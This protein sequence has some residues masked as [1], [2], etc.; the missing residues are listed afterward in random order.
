[1][2]H[3][4]ACAGLPV[5][6]EF[7]FALKDFLA[8]SGHWGAKIL[9][10]S[11]LAR[12]YA[13][14]AFVMAL[15][16]LVATVLALIAQPD[17]KRIEQYALTF[18]HASQFERH[19]DAGPVAGPQAVY[20]PFHGG[21]VAASLDES[22]LPSLRPGQVTT[23]DRY[24]SN[25]LF[26]LPASA[27]RPAQLRI[28]AQNDRLPAGLGAI[29]VGPQ[30]PLQDF[31]R[32]LSRA[33]DRVNQAMP[34]TVLLCLL[35]A[36]ALVF[37]SG[38]PARYAYMAGLFA[39]SAAIEFD[40][41]LTVAG[42]H[43]RDFE[44][45]V[46]L[47]Y[48]SFILLAISEWW[49]RPDRER[50][51]ILIGMAIVGAMVVAGD[52]WFGM[53]AA[54]TRVLRQLAFIGPLIAA[55]IY[56]ILQAYRG[57]RGASLEALVALACSALA[58]FAALI[59]LVRLYTVLPPD[60]LTLVLF[61]TKILGSLSLLTLSSAA[62]IHEYRLFALRRS[63]TQT[64]D[65]I[66]SGT[67]LAIDEQARELKDEIERRAVSEE[68]VRLT[69]DLHDGLSGQLL[70]LLLKAR[71]GTIA[72][73][74]VEREVERSLAD[75][76]LISSALDESEDG[77]TGTLAKFQARAAQQAD[78]SGMRLDWQQ[79]PAIAQFALARRA[80]LGLLRAMQEA[81]TN[82][83]RHSRGSKITIDLAVRESQLEV[84]ITDD[85]I[86][87]PA[88]PGSYGPGS[89]LRN[90]RQRMIEN[91]G[92]CVLETGPDRRGLVVRLTLPRG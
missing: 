72:P 55:T 65:R 90:I 13:V 68:R 27:D 71:T 15:G 38:S 77:F 69:R 48:C 2:S 62:L 4:T 1:M 51:Y 45:Y 9:G 63:T 73:A 26:A 24:R 42:L 3:R 57:F 87:L 56:W 8:R 41:S 32:A 40:R 54:P 86:G 61:E 20:L 79:A 43:L 34:L 67:N 18:E 23:A 33:I 84:S 28:E 88:D 74:V 31:D 66:V 11:G 81:V 39:C 36:L 17:F 91:E 80:Q 21:K 60:M 22:V 10:S 89:G 5:V 49:D 58:L 7:R 83:L 25:S 47:A 29:Y 82:A 76:R 12:Q 75:L 92:R 44:S 37:L 50:R 52:L 59:N 6:A 78:W 64:M 53:S 14:I 19:I 35:L 70:S 46:G 85:G 30:G 16:L